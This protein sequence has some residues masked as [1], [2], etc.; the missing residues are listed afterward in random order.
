MSFYDFQKPRIFGV[1]NQILWDN[2]TQLF[3]THKTM[4]DW[5]NWDDW[6]PYGVHG[7]AVGWGTVLQAGR[8]GVQFPMVSLEFFVDIILPATL[9][10]WGWLSL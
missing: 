8:S 10:P 4:T 5:E 9:Q 1:M 2:G 7:G 3:T 6:D